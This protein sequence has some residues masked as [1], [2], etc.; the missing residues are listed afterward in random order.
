MDMRLSTF[1]SSISTNFTYIFLHIIINTMKPR[2][3]L[4]RLRRR[5]CRRTRPRRRGRCRHPGRCSGRGSNYHVGRNIHDRHGFQEAMIGR[6]P[7][8]RADGHES[9][10]GEQ[11]GPDVRHG[12]RGD[13]GRWRPRRCP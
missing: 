6:L 2:G 9:V 3:S 11:L 5:V 1:Y 8:N 13:G 10:H 12:G 7:I 4:I